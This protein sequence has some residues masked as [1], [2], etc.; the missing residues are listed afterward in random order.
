MLVKRNVDLGCA[1]EWLSRIG[2]SEII[3]VGL[4]KSLQL[5]CMRWSVRN[6]VN[7]CLGKGDGRGE[8]RSHS[9]QKAC[10][11]REF[12]RNRAFADGHL[13]NVLYCL[14][15]ET[16]LVSHA[17]VEW[18]ECSSYATY[19]QGSN[20]ILPHSPL[21][22]L[23]YHSGASLMFTTRSTIFAGPPT[24]PNTSCR[25]RSISRA[26]GRTARTGQRP[27]SNDTF[28]SYTSRPV[29]GSGGA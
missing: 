8:K 26:C 5:I 29:N 3:S 24:P 17:L 13:L 21:S 25:A 2:H 10:Q 18:T 12:L 28:L 9:F 20:R 22:N 11:I 15:E 6:K 19:A 23:A 27:K 7:P 4:K 16:F 1:F 14:D